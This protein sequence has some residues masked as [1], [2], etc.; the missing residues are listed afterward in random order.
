LG[1]AV[2]VP[3]RAIKQRSVKFP[4]ELAHGDADGGLGP[5]HAFC[6]SADTTLFDHG[7]EHFKLH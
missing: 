1:Q 2:L 4:L 7:Y 6:G 3:L 5:E